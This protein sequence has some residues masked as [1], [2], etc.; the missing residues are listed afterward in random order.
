MAPSARRTRGAKAASVPAA[1][2]SPPAK[3]LKTEADSAWV[4]VVKVEDEKRNEEKKH[5]TTPKRE[6]NNTKGGGPSFTSPAPGTALV[7][8]LYKFANPVNP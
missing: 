6:K 5:A 7:V 3:K 8:G 1:P 4:D 2:A